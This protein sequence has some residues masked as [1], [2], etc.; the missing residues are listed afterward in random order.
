VLSGQDGVEARAAVRGIQQ[1]LDRAAGSFRLEY[2]CDSPT[3]SR[4]FEM[5]VFPLSGARSGAVIAHEIIT[6]QKKAEG[7][8]RAT[9]EEVKRHDQQMVILNRMNDLLLSCET[10]QEAYAIIAQTAGTLF[11]PHAGG[12]AVN[13]GVPS[14]LRRVAVWGDPDR[15]S[16]FFSLR[17]CWGLRRGALHEVEPSRNEMDCRHFPHDPPSTYLCAP[18]N[19]RGATLGLLHVSAS[20]ALTEAQ[21]QELRTL[22]IAVSESIKLTL[23]NL[24]LREALQNRDIEP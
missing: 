20:A 14:E 16:P 24:R 19:V 3:E 7:A 11:A 13:N 5:R 2:P 4:W 1:V 9:L 23:S 22:A 6:A 10:D 17:D 15:L 18:L 12:L 8:L 21:F